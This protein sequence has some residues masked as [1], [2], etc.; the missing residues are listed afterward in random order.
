MQWASGVNASSRLGGRTTEWGG[1]WERNTPHPTPIAGSVGR[2]CGGGSAPPQK[3]FC[4][5]ISKWY[6]LVNSEMLNIKF[7]FIQKL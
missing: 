4:F 6:I 7:F 1:V 3:I 2:V 5:M